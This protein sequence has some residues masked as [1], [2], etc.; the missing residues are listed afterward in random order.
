M[1]RKNDKT[2][3]QGKNPIFYGKP[4]EKSFSMEEIAVGLQL[5][6][7]SDFKLLVQTVATMEREKSVEFNKKGKIRLPQKNGDIEGTFRANERALGL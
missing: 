4:D 3:N 5:Q 2:N 7:S 1:R 6:K